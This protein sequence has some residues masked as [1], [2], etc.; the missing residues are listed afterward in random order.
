[1]VNKNTTLMAV[2]DV[3]LGG[4]NPENL[5]ALAE[6]VLRTGDVVV[7]QLEVPYT[8]RVF[9]SALGRDPSILSILA[10]ANFKVLTF[11]GN[12]TA[13]LGVPGIEDSIAGVRKYGMAIVGAGMNIDEARKPAIIERN[14]V[15]FGFL[16][17]NC[18]GP[19]ETWASP[20]RPGCAYVYIIT[21][22]ELDYAVP[23]GPPTIYTWAEYKTLGAMAEDIRK[24]RPLCDVLIVS[25][26]KGVIHTP[27]KLMAYEQLVSYAAIDAGADVVLGHHQHILQGIEMYKGKPIFHGLCNFGTYLPGLAPKPG[28][29]AQSWARRRRDLFGFDPDPEYPTYPFHP[30]AKYTIIAKCTVQNGRVSRVSYLPCLVNKQAQPDVL[31]HDAKGQEIFDYVDKITRGTGLNARFEWAGDEVVIRAE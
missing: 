29:D 6:P 28:Q 13:D 31:K 14:G 21:H 12:H 27:M 9:N 15:R 10:S 26:H 2:G 23:G 5:L 22:Y 11:V 16:G 17:Y 24:L 18:V 8:N 3:I 25:L 4:P 30:E 19:K 1:M 20:D 7:G